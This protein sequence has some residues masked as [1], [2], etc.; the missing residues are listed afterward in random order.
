MSMLG[1]VVPREPAVADLS[2]ADAER[3]FTA[4]LDGEVPLEEV[5][6]RLIG[7]APKAC[8][9]VSGPTSARSYLNL[10]PRRYAGRLRFP[11]PSSRW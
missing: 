1:S 10:Q 4:I 3:L 7:L 8:C 6:R 9:A 2:A 5:G 11:R